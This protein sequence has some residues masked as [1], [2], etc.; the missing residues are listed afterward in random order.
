MSAQIK[1]KCK[2]EKNGIDGSEFIRIPKLTTTHCD[3]NAFRKHPR[4]G[5]LANSKMF[6]MALDRDLLMNQG[7][8]T[9]CYVPLDKLPDSVT[10]DTSKFLAVVTIDV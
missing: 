9:E 7:I 5:S 2:I 4:L 6:I 10:V 8:R 1:F 3:M